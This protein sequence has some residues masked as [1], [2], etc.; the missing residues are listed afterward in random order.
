MKVPLEQLT[1]GSSPDV[2]RL[3]SGYIQVAMRITAHSCV[4]HDTT[5]RILS[6][7]SLPTT[8]ILSGHQGAVGMLLT[9]SGHSCLCCCS[10]RTKLSYSMAATRILS[11]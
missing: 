5:I 7:H 2:F 9:E 8:V 6:G 11:V 4:S 10:I 3:L 1:Q